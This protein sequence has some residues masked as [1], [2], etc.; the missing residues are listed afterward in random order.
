MK[1][2]LNTYILLWCAYSLQ[3]VLYPSGSLTSRALAFIIIAIS[4]FFFIEVLLRYKNNPVLKSLSVLVVVFSIYGVIS[5]A[6][7]NGLSSVPSSSYLKSIYLS[8]LPV[9]VFYSFSVKKI[10]TPRYLVSW[11]PIF[12]LVAIATHY[13]Y[14]QEELLEAMSIGSSREEFTNNAGYV[15]LSLF[16]IIPMIKKASI[17][18]AVLGFCLAFI[19]VGMKRGAIVIAVLSTVYFFIQSLINSKGVKERIGVYLLIFVVIVVAVYVF[20]YYLVN[21]SFFNARL[22]QTLEGN[23]SGRDEIYS[24]YLHHF[25]YNTTGFTFF[26]GGGADETLR[27]WGLRAHDDWLEIAIN[28]GLWVVIMYFIYWFYIFRFHN[29][30]DKKSIDYAVMSL[31]IIIF[32]SRTIISMSYNDIT[33]YASSAFGYELA[34][35]VTCS[36]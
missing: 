13:R 1:H 32:F 35:G 24:T 18:Y 10:I 29:K 3:G 31:F 19:I 5:I 16:P 15:F 6:F 34:R 30:L 9:F 14:H 4:L 27:L 12:I 17:R 21:S 36:S 8:L 23:S 7:G 11:L 33:I 22:Q 20:N 28:N 26:F 25:L 2:F